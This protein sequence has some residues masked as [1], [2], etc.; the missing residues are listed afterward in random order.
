MSTIE[1]SLVR[2]AHAYTR[3]KTPWQTDMPEQTEGVTPTGVR[4]GWRLVHYLSGNWT[5]ADVKTVREEEA[6]MAQTRFL[7]LASALAAIWIWCLV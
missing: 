7:V 4:F 6:S 2:D 1:T 5:G 3:S